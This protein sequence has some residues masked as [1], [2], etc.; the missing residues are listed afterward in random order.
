[1]VVPV[2]V[3]PPWLSTVTEVDIIVSVVVVVV[4][5]ILVTGRVVVVVLSAASVWVTLI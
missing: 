5:T 4:D 3:L 2:K 1:M